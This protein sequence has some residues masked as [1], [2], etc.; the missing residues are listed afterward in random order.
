VA[1]DQH[2]DRDPGKTI[3]RVVARYIGQPRV[4]HRA[5]QFRD[6]LHGVETLRLARAIAILLLS[7]G[8]NGRVL[9]I[10]LGFLSGPMFGQFQPGRIDHHAPQIALL[11]FVIGASL[12]ALDG[13]RAR[14]AAL[15]GALTALSLA[16]SIENLRSLS[17]C[18]RRSRSLLWFMAL[19]FGRC[20]SG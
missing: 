20:C 7:P 18:M 3:G 5:L 17:S 19:P 16:I 10:A 12:A 11:V 13:S 2:R 8:G 6:E 1:G 9:A 15:A 14:F 4:W